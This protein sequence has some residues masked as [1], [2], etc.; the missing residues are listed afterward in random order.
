RRR[1]PGILMGLTIVELA[2]AELIHC[3]DCNAKSEV[4]VDEFFG[5]IV[6]K[7]FP[8]CAH[9]SWRLSMNYNPVSNVS[10]DG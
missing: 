10:K 7:K 5:L 3:F 8:I 2:L 1:C 9:P 4:N 6:P